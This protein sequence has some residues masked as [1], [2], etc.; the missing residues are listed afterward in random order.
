MSSYFC[1]MKFLTS[2]FTIALAKVDHHET[3][4]FKVY[5]G[6]EVH[7]H[8]GTKVASSLAVLKTLFTESGRFQMQLYLHCQW[9]DE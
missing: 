6:G 5:P 8:T 9:R 3:Q 1:R 7:T 4:E 2:L